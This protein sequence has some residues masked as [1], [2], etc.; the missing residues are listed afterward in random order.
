MLEVESSSSDGQ[1]KSDSSSENSSSDSGCEPDSSDDSRGRRPYRRSSTFRPV[2][3]GGIPPGTDTTSSPS[4]LAT[5]RAQMIAGR[6]LHVG[7]AST[8][9]EVI[10]API[11]AS[12]HPLPGVIVGAATRSRGHHLDRVCVL[13]YAE[14]AWDRDCSRDHDRRRCYSWDRYRDRVHEDFYSLEIVS[15]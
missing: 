5:A 9:I 12:R 2:N 14:S 15:A 7:I 10:T 13:R 1:S 3:T 4:G 6:H 11:V 8:T